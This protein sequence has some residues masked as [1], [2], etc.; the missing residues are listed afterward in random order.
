[1]TDRRI[2]ALDPKLDALQLPETAAAQL[3]A[4]S[5]AIRSQFRLRSTLSDPTVPSPAREQIARALFADRIG[6]PAAEAVAV[7]AG[8]LADSA[9]L[10]RAVER[11]GVRAALQASGDLDR[12]QDELFRLA[13]VIDSDSELQ[14]TL[15]DPGVELA[16]RQKLVSDLLAG[17]AHPAT[18]LLLHRGLAGRGRTLVKT[19]DGYVEVAAEI[20][21][22]AVAKVSVA[23]PLTAAQL[24]QLEAQ[25]VRIYGVGIDVE[26]NIDPEVL[27]GVRIEVG[28]EL[29]DGTL[30]HRVDQARRLIG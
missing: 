30:A 5:D 28:D 1:M 21:S 23:Q 26:V 29:I 15:G 22:H 17:R 24:A 18:E 25:L 8:G 19:L 7:L 9:L 27:G 16:A 6:G 14:T 11:A 4:A 20:R 3:F 2:T 12:V 10:V 13:R